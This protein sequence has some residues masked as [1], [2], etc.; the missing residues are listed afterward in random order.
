L[1]IEKIKQGQSARAIPRQ[2]TTNPSRETLS[3]HPQICDLTEMANRKR[4]YLNSTS[5][6]ALDSGFQEFL[7]YG[8]KVPSAPGYRYSSSATASVL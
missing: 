6:I 7:R 8:I 4:F 3:L 2:E 1:Q 5:A